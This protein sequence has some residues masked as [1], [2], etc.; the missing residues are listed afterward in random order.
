MVGIQESKGQAV[1]VHVVNAET[2]L[3]EEKVQ[4]GFLSARLGGGSCSL[5]AKSSTMTSPTCVQDSLCWPIYQFIC[6]C[7][8]RAWPQ[9]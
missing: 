1:P 3:S 9:H 2:G 7:V 6:C 4:K 5:S 8:L